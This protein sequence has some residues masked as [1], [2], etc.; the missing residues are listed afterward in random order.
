MG[1]AKENMLCLGLNGGRMCVWK[2]CAAGSHVINAAYGGPREQS[3]TE[4]RCKQSGQMW[5]KNR[6]GLRRK[7][8]ICA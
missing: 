6:S 7:K 4:E 3:H 5:H 2:L 1:E 8:Q